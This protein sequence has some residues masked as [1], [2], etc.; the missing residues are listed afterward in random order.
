MH[1]LSIFYQLYLNIT[2]INLNGFHSIIL[3]T[4]A[5]NGLNLWNVHI[6]NIITVKVLM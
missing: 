5:Q 2:S 4:T 3:N 6:Q 1:I